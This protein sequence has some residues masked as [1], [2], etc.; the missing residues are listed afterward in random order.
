MHAR[1]FLGG[2]NEKGKGNRKG[3]KEENGKGN[4]KVDEDEGRV[5]GNVG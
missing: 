4:R 2:K 3:K 5:G 1:R